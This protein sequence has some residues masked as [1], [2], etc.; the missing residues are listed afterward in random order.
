[1]VKDSGTSEEL[2]KKLQSIGGG[3]NYRAIGA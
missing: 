3:A 2:F 1:M